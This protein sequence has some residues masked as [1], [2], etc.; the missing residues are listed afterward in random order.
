MKALFWSAAVSSGSLRLN[1]RVDSAVERVVSLLDKRA[2]RRVGEHVGRETALGENL[3][4]GT[5]EHITVERHA[6]DLARGESQQVVVIE[7]ADGEVEKTVMVY[8][9]LLRGL[10]CLLLVFG[11]VTPTRKNRPRLAV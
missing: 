8:F 2:H 3:T 1:G 6:P 7:R 11:L 9:F 4:H 10:G 5:V